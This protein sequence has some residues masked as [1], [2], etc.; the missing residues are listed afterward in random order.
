MASEAQATEFRG[1]HLLPGA[2]VRESLWL[3]GATGVWFLVLFVASHMRHAWFQSNLFDLGIFD[4]TL[5]LIA[6]DAPPIATTLGF[7][8]LGDHASVILWPLAL[9]YRIAP[10]VEWLFGVQALALALGSIPLRAMARERGIGLLWTR[11]LTLSYLLYPAIFNAALFDFHPEVIAVPALL[12]AAR[13][14]LQGRALPM[15]AWLALALACKEVLGL[16]V[17]FFG[18]WLFLEGRRSLGASAVLL[19][20]GWFLLAAG[21]MIPAFSGRGPAGLVRY[22]YLGSSAREILLHAITNPWLVASH[23]LAPEAVAYTLSLVLPV[24]G[25]LRFDDWR[26]LVPAL[27]AWSLNVLS[28]LPSQRDL[29]HQYALPILPFVFLWAMR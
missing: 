8:M 28:V 25:L 29:V 27:P 20:L 1:G 22:G 6:H 10:S 16:T 14:G 4:Q 19:G 17:L 2:D 13:A 3:A 9:L 23:L 11:T 5:W 15:L 12:W 21:W 7:H 18:V 24:V 26:P